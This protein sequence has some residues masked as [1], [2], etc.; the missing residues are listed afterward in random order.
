MP[1]GNIRPQERL[2]AGQTLLCKALG[3]KVPI[4]TPSVSTPN[5]VRRGLRQRRAPSHP[6]HS[7]GHSHGRDEHLMYRFVDAGTRRFCTRNPLRRGQVEGRDFFI[8]EQG[9]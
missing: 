4:G 5:A 2:C 6:G 9:S 7:P 1:S 8:L 3:L